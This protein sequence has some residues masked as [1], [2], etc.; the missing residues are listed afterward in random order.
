[1]RDWAVLMFVFVGLEA[2]LSALLMLQA[3]VFL[4]GGTGMSV[5]ERAMSL[6]PL[7]F[8]CW[9]AYRLIRDRARLA[10]AMFPSSPEEGATP[11]PA[12]LPV[13]GVS[14]V[15]LYVT[16]AGAPEFLTWFFELPAALQA[17]SEDIAGTLTAARA[18]SATVD[19][20][21]GALI[22]INR[23]AIADRLVGGGGGGGEAA[24][25]E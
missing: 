24:T 9:V 15:G 10:D 7:A 19:I 4:A 13:L 8:L 2:G 18:L 23:E 3:T 16:V 20:V 12:G 11:S 5:L 6:V 17:R 14:L 22:V 1:M 25:A 21:A